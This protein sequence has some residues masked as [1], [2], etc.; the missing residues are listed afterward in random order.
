M[1]SSPRADPSRL[2]RVSPSCGRM[3]FRMWCPSDSVRKRSKTCVCRLQLYCLSV[4][5]TNIGMLFW[6][7]YGPPPLGSFHSARLVTSCSNLI[8][9]VVAVVGRGNVGAVGPRSVSIGWR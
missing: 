5:C 3:T 7:G 8:F 1:Y 9:F 6:A 2:Y 4:L